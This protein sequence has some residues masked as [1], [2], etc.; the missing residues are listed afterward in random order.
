MV[1]IAS[2]GGWFSDA[3]AFTFG[4]PQ[5]LNTPGASGG[6]QIAA[7]GQNVFAAWIQSSNVFVANSVN[8]GTFSS[9][10]QISITGN[11]SINPRIAAAGD[12]VYAVWVDTSVGS[13][14][15][16]F[17][18]GAV[19]GGAL[20]M[21]AP[22][23]LSNT[24]A[25][26]EDPQLSVSGNNVVVVWEET[27]SGFKDIFY[28]FST[29]GGINFDTSSTNNLSASPSITSGSASIVVSGSNVFV[30]WSEDDP[31]NVVVSALFAKGTISGSTLTFSGL[32][33]L[34][35]DICFGFEDARNPKVLAS[36][37]DVFVIWLD[38]LCNDIYYAQ[39]ANSGSSFGVPADS[40]DNNISSSGSAADFDAHLSGGSLFVVWVD[41]GVGSGDIRFARGIISSG[42]LNISIP[43][44][45]SST[46][47]SSSAPQVASSGS[48]VYVVWRENSPNDI[49]LSVS[50]DGGSTA[51]SG[52]INVSS[53]SGQ[54]SA[55]RMATSGINL[56]TVWVDNTSGSDNILFKLIVDQPASISIASTSST[57]PRWGLDAVQV[58][59][60]VTGD[61]T[62]SI[63]VNWGDG[64]TDSV[65]LTGS[66]WGPVS[67]TY[68]STATGAR[69]ITARLLDSSMAEKASD[70][71]DIN[72]QK[73]ATALTI[74]AIAS[75][76]K[77]SSI[78]ASGTLTDT[79]ASVSLDGKTIT[80][81]GTGAA[82]LSP[83]A[84]AAGAYSSIGASPGTASQ[85]LSVQA[86]FA[87]D[88]A[89]SA[90]DSATVFYDTVEAG[91]SS[92]TVP[93]GA[94]SGPIALT[95][96]GALILL[97][98]VESPGSALVSTCD[99]PASA[100]YLELDL[101]LCL[102]ISPTFTMTPNSFA[103]ITVSYAGRTIP[104]GHL[105]DEVSIFHN[106]PSGI[107]DITESRDTNAD[108][109]TGRTFGFSSFIV[110]VALHDP[111]PAGALRKQLFVG[112]NDITFDFSQTKAVSF[113]GGSTVIGGG[114]PVTV[115]DPSKNT[116]SLVAET[117]AVTIAST[118]DP[119]GITI[120]LTETGSNT[121]VFTSNVFISTSGSSGNILRAKVGD[122]VQA[123]YQEYTKAT[124]RV[125]I[126]D[127]IEAGAVDLV[128]YTPPNFIDPVGDSYGLVLRDASLAAGA[129]ISPT[130]SYANAALLGGDNPAN[131]RM[132]RMDGTTCKAEITLTGGAGHNPAQ[133]TLTGTTAVLG[134]Y[135]LGL[136]GPPAPGLCPADPGGGGGGL[137][138]PG[139]GLVLDAV[140]VVV[141][142]SSGGSSPGSSSASAPS[143]TSSSQVSSNNASTTTNIGGETVNVS[144]ESV[145]GTGS[146][147]VN[148]INI[149]QQTRLFSQITNT[150]Q[151][152][153]SVGGSQFT[154]VGTL[155][156]V[157]T[158][159]SYS[160]PVQITIPY[161]ES[162]VPDEQNV[163]FLHHGP[164]GWEDATVSI[165]MQSNTVTGQVISLSPMVAGVVEDGT[166]G[167][168][169]FAANPTKRM[170]IMDAQVTGAP[171]EL[172]LESTSETPSQ[173]SLQ[174]T[175]K[176]LQRANQTYAFIV[177]VIDGEDITREISWQKG[178]LGMGESTVLL[179]AWAGDAGAYRVKMFVWT[180]VSAPAALSEIMVRDIVVG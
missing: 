8:G 66:P 81:T 135:T 23:A 18:K 106:G 119:V 155:L 20:S 37:T 149:S 120:D 51:P 36:G 79:D 147:N 11:T 25:T 58:N 87:G 85:L 146:V 80:F 72:V 96:F 103:H 6:A 67:H 38:G 102:T 45:L 7:S 138:R 13:G 164:D 114:L 126:E 153:G 69:T 176:N 160:G 136:N 163:R 166:F 100:R 82:G 130:M 154:T 157:S 151:G 124:F 32:Q 56:Y 50:T 42:S 70:T 73:H 39:S 159:A 9:P 116:N 168:A 57:T 143:G 52:S 112:D 10:I 95:G 132:F 142:G 171:E 122:S 180:D 1:L 179:S 34:S 83:A 30:A 107:V 40:S 29:D 74:G 121:G 14:D 90:A 104:A 145:Q 59:G 110:G 35:S 33:D 91:T 93:S 178:E 15:I 5:T 134:Q 177:M 113:R 98:D 169:Y 89:Y 28:A 68:A 165:N 115:N 31:L 111:L 139:S 131:I 173:P 46:A 140:A 16:Y 3:L 123:A 141:Q 128:G 12:S 17:A 101:D 109:V 97:D 53:N 152:A 21:S 62:D 55:P 54:S 92:F 75:V 78:T 94:P 77:G 43:V 148:S 137:P 161:N 108:T 118:S 144:F 172:T 63:E 65:G 27:V 48:N 125:V 19:S 64:A 127:V 86:H 99:S 76:V 170:S 71:L 24:P 156:D 49:F 44:N 22:V 2:A 60:L 150:G 4:S 162:L 117:V 47:S 129:A 175:I 26:S 41:S 88:G 167:E 61:F 158:T 174:V 105:E 133:K 84:T